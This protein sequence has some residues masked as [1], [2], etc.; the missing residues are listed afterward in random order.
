[1][2]VGQAGEV[3]VDIGCVVE[4]LE[5]EVDTAAAKTPIAT[6]HPVDA[7][8]LFLLLTLCALRNNQLTSAS[9]SS[10]LNRPSKVVKKLP[11]H[12]LPM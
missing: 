7:L 3:L 11:R 8:L 2:A 1:M 12:T 10:N 6:F 4:A 5:D 9:S